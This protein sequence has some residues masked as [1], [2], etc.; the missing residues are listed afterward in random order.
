[1]S[2]TSFSVA[3][4]LSSKKSMLQSLFDKF[5][6]KGEQE[7]SVGPSFEEVNSIAQNILGRVKHRPKI[8]IVCGSGLGGLADDVQDAEILP[9]SEIPTFPVSTVPGHMGKLVFGILEGKTVV[10]MRGRLHCY[11]GYPMWKTTIPIRVMKALGVTTI[12]LTNAAGGINPDFNVG[13][14]MIIRDHI[15]LPGLTGECVLRGANDER[16]GPRFLA[17]VDTY[18]PELRA[19]CKKVFQDLGLSQL[20]R[21]GTYVMIGGPTFETVAESR[22]LKAFG[23]DSVGMSTVAE[24]IVA[25]HMGMRVFGLSLITDMCCLSY[26]TAN[27]TTH[28]EVLAIGQKRAEDLKAIVMRLLKDTII[29]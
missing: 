9:Y 7:N 2:D 1:M 5:T 21:E 25:R 15:D 4:F 13:D 23:G 28:E 3:K 22:L 12:F 27:H 11:E 24:A 17:T 10:L 26:D 14:M 6:S 20:M 29:E 19:T 18:D 16:F 8:G